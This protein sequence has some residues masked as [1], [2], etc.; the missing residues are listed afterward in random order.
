[1]YSSTLDFYYINTDAVEKTYLTVRM[2]RGEEHGNVTFPPTESPVF[3]TIVDN[4]HA[5]VQA[6]Y[7]KVCVNRIAVRK[8]DLL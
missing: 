1:M 4:S 7:K 6:F 8:W 3:I 2:E 5:C